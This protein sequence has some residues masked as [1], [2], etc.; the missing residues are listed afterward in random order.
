MKKTRETIECHCCGGSGQIEMTGVY[1]ETLRLLRKQR[2]PVNGAQLAKLAGCKA[3]AMNNRLS[4]LWSHGKA[5]FE[6]RGRE[7]LWRA[8]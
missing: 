6:R 2:K 3:T 7:T 5:N 4:R 8:V 1:L